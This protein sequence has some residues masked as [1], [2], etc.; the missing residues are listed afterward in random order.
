M[1]DK[2]QITERDWP[3]HD[4][5]REE[6]VVEGIVMALEGCGDND[7]QAVVT[8]AYGRQLRIIGVRRNGN[9]VELVVD[10]E[11]PAR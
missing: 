5:P 4:W 2:I 9:R 8:D 6:I 11:E 7:D 10:T 1:A 3:M